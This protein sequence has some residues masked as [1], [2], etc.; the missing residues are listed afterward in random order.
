MN[1][2]KTK[3]GM[4][5]N[6][7]ALVVFCF[8]SVLISV[9][10][11]GKRVLTF[12]E[13]IR[14]ALKNSISLNQQKNNLEF[15]QAQRTSNLAGLGPTLGFSASAT[16]VDGNTF[17][18]QQ[19]K[20]INGIFDQVSASFN[21]NWNLFNGFSQIHRAKQSSSQL[22]AQA[23]YVNRSS[24]DV[25]NSITS[26]YLQVLL[27]KE[28]LKIAIENWEALKKQLE[29]VTEQ[30]NVGA[31]SPVDQYN[32]ESQTSAAEIRALQAEINLTN[33]R[34]ALT[35]ML[36]QDPSDEFDVAKPEWDINKQSID[37]ME[38]QSL[39]DLS[40]KSRGD[41]LRAQKSE[42]A[43]KYGMRAARGAMTPTLSAFGTLYSAYNNS[44]GD[45]TT[46]PFSDQFKDDNLRKIYGLQLNV[47]IFGGN[48]GFQNRVALVQ[49]KVTYYNSVLARK[50]IEIQVKTDVL[51][52]HQ[53]FQLY[54]KTFSASIQQFKAA[55]VAYQLETERYNLGVTNFVDFSNAN[56]VFVQAQTDKA[57]AEYRL[58]FQKVLVDYAVGTLKPEDFQ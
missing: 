40:L 6:R 55:E 48:Q 27:D 53:N 38:L 30:V 34:A 36:L 7:I 54:S 5:M 57:Q 45:P 9:A 35:L 56:K 2:L 52:A 49:Q 23:Y 18:Q 37:K 10:Q 8:F 28:L 33:D 39:F 32:Q 58:L 22:D 51:R 26:A 41:Y 3:N 25:I 14:I 42:D 47:P 43:A 44:Y 15:N 20:V 46:R 31:K 17:N 1:W 13:A 12:E 16:Q 4:Y 24:Q 50:N 21:A 29:Q 19:G 11:E